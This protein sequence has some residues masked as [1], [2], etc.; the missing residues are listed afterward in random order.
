MNERFTSDYLLANPDLCNNSVFMHDAVSYDPSL[1]RFAHEKCF[2][3]PDFVKDVFLKYRITVDDF[4]ANPRL[5]GNFYIMKFLPEFKLYRSYLSFDDKVD[6]IVSCLKSGNDIFSL[7]FFDKRLVSDLDIDSLKRL[8]GVLNIVV[9]VNDMDVQEGYFNL[10][11]SLVDGVVLL[12]YDKA[13]ASFKYNGV[14]SLNSSFIRSFDMAYKSNSYDYISFLI[15]DICSF[16]DNSVSFT[17]VSEM[18]N[19]FYS[20]FVSSGSIDLS[21]TDEFCNFVLNIHRN[22]YISNLKKKIVN[23]LYYRFDLT[24]KKTSSVLNSRKL[25]E[26]SSIISSGNYFELGLSEEEFDVFLSDFVSSISSNKYILKYGFNRS[27]FDNLI[28]YFKANGNMDNFGVINSL[29]LVDHDVIK[30]VCDKFERFKLKFVDRISL[31]S[32]D[33]FISNYT[34]SNIGFNY[35]NFLIFN[36]DVFYKNLAKVLL[37]DLDFSKIFSNNYLSEVVCLLNFADIFSDFS[38]D[39]FICIISSYDVVREKINGFNKINSLISLSRA[40]SSLDSI[41]LVALGSDFF[42]IDSYCDYVNFYF[43]MLDRKYGYI[44]SVSFSYDGFDFN[45]GVYAD[46]DRL[47]IGH[48]VR[49]NSCVTLGSD[50][51]RDVLLDP[52]GDVILV[53]K[54]GQVVSRILMFRR[55]NVI[56]LV[57]NINTKFDLAVYEKICDQIVSKSFDDNIDFVFVNCSSYIGDDSKYCVICDNRFI[58]EFPHADFLNNSL[59]LYG[60][61]VSFLDF[62]CEPKCSYGKVRCDVVDN[63]SSSSIDRIRALD[64]LMESDVSLRM[65]KK[66][67]F[68]PFISDNY[69]YCICGEDFYVA[70]DNSGE[71]EEVVLP[72]CYSYDEVVVVRE[73]INSFRNV[74]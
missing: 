32:D 65:V 43:K 59:M 26:I 44:P 30:Y 69:K 73:R 31:S 54:D 1:I 20:Y 5:C 38:I 55:G 47:L 42:G 28:S 35:N 15:D 29:G 8:F 56:Q 49:A 17:Y 66:A 58:T 57:S 70:L 27:M 48:N 6:A 41:E 36:Y 45:S 10:L 50:T 52:S 71:M 68:Q 39:D 34:K 74:K 14:A 23:G 16:L 3:E 12:N 60:D 4:Y 21:V 53:R 72:C 25:S 18:V 2:F 67:A 61:N 62:D 64:I 24:D 22:N 46:V 19:S 63:P 33:S 40:Y 11:D 13:R 7:P 37:S 9:D 51:F